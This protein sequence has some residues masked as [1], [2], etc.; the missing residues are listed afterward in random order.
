[1]ND[2]L[3]MACP[4][5]ASMNPQE[6]AYC[7]KCG[8]ALSV[9]VA[10][11]PS[12]IAEPAHWRQFIG[13]RADVYMEQFRIFREGTQE[14]FAPSWHWPAFGVGW[15]WYLYRKM[16]LHAAIFLFGGLLPMVLGAGLVGVVI[17]NLFAAVAAKYLYYMHI[18]LSL[19]MIDRRAGLDQD[20]RDHLI[21]DAGGIQP[22]VW[23]LGAGLMALAIG[24][25]LMEAPVPISPPS[26]GP[27][28]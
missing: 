9:A 15:L 19:A 8:Q 6:S 7:N 28:A 18:K 11:A 1:M 26:P 12:L 13:P 21:H 17:W 25:G 20:M 5:C 14:R 22:Y 10:P 2:T 23:W 27:P 4:H 16:Y 3:Q 24:G